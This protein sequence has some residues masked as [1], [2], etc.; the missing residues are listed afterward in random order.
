MICN[1]G[2][3]FK[4]IQFWWHYLKWDAIHNDK[5]KYLLKY[6]KKQM[7]E[8]IFFFAA[9]KSVAFFFLGETSRRKH[10]YSLSDMIVSRRYCFCLIWSFDCNKCCNN[11]MLRYVIMYRS[12]VYIYIW[13]GYLLSGIDQTDHEDLRIDVCPYRHPV[14]KNCPE[15]K[16]YSIEN[17]LTAEE[18]KTDIFKIMC[19]VFKIVYNI[20]SVN[21]NLHSLIIN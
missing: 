14:Y 7:T 1:H 9:S 11:F 18:K 5:S 16:N 2:Q 10:I 19:N 21:N 4:N 8:F 6:T 12:L 15:Y 3:K 13:L 17:I 20:K